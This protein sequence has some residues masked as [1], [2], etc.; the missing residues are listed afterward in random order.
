MER[1]RATLVLATTLVVGLTSSIG[2]GVAAA[3]PVARTA[4]TAVPASAAE[5]GTV[6]QEGGR[7]R[8]PA[9]IEGPVTL[10]LKVTLPAGVTGPV[11]ADIGLPVRSFP[12]AGP[13]PH[14]LAA[15]L[16]STCA[17]NGGAFSTCEWDPPW[18][19][20]EDYP[21]PVRL[22]L[23]VTEAA[24]TLTYQVTIDTSSDQAWVGPL[25]APV[26]LKDSTGAVV[27]T[28][29]AGLDFGLGTPE[30]RYI[31]ALHA[32]DK[33]GVLWRYDG[34]GHTDRPFFPRKKVGGGWNVYT[35]VVPIISPRG[36]GTGELV[37]R[38]K[39]G[40]LWYYK[41]TNNPEAPF[42]PRVRVGAG[43]DI[44]TSLVGRSNGALVARDKSGVLW[45][46]ER[47]QSGRVP[48]IPRK[49]VGGGWNIYNSVI[50]YGGGPLARD[51]AGVLWKYDETS[52]GPLGPEGY[53]FRWPFKVGGGWNIYT[54]VAGTADLGPRD[55]LD[56]VVARDRSGKLWLYQGVRKSDA[57]VPGPVRT[58]VG[59]GWNIYD[60]IF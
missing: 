23:P 26:Q 27:A 14:R 10:R 32:R 13:S 18:L 25:D 39:A 55:Y 21:Y 60:L 37:A 12:P 45:N 57:I 1:T 38:D 22:K 8:V 47:D 56:D 16:H 54:A 50:G 4:S 46:Y 19:D 42:A 2:G 20:G 52:D 31:G 36:D 17:V 7:L 28:G 58:P 30:G 15:A 41:G 11:R 51:K 34:T 3:A 44:Y 40:V 59:N 53:P 29:T 9:G 49:K 5:V 24:P 43:W 6:V 33:N 35:A 48:F